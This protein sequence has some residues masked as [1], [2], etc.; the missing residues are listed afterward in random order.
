MPLSVH[1][2]L[3]NLRWLAPG[4]GT[5]R[6]LRAAGV[7]EAH[8]QTPPAG[9]QQFDSQALWR[10]LGSQN[11]SGKR[12][13]IVRGDSLDQPLSEVSPADGSSPSPG[14]DW[15]AQRWTQ[16]GASVDFAVVYTRRAPLLTA[17][18]CDRARQGSRDGS[19]WLFSSSEA[20][21]H[22]QNMTAL[23]DVD[24]REARAVATHP[25]IAARVRAAG[26]GVVAES[27]PTLPDIG[28]SIESLGHA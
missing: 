23:A 14:R 21:G 3:T 24:W 13:L 6:A 7:P 10:Q 17:A 28:R 11:W 4:P 8:I 12:V 9:A 15:I 27:R 22:L 20:V 25:R 19:V 18:E 26:W 16:A 1:G 2:D 5:A